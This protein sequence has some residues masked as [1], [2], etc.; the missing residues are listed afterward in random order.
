MKL[1]FN[2]LMVMVAFT[3]AK[4]HAEFG[5]EHIFPYA[6]FNFSGVWQTEIGDEYNIKQKGCSRLEIEREYK[7]NAEVQKTTI[8]PDGKARK[9]TGNTW[10][11]EIRH[12]WDAK[13]YG[14][15]VE[16]FAEIVYSDRKVKETV[17]LE[18]VNE[19]LILET[20]YRT[21]EITGATPKS[22]NYQRIFRR[23]KVS[24]SGDRAR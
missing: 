1:V 14:A 4:V 5:D 3:A 23:A 11:G 12:R 6:C 22:E 17:L 7:G 18:S 24:S 15:T 16:S 20:L 13:N 9:V 21:T 10:K 2:L 19:N 8:V